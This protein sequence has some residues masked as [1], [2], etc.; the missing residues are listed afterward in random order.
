MNI[1]GLNLRSHNASATLIQD[2]KLITSVEEERLNREK[3]SWK[4]PHLSIEYSL[5]EAKID[6]KDIDAVGI[7]WKSSASVGKRL[8]HGFK[9]PT[10]LVT[11]LF[12]HIKNIYSISR[13]PADVSK[14][15]LRKDCKIVEVEHHLAHASSCFFV[16]PFEEAAILTLDGH[17]EWATTLLAEGQNKNIAKIQ[18]LYW[19]HSLGEF[20]RS[21]ASYLGFPEFGD[22]YKVMGLAPY[23]KPKYVEKVRKIVSY[24]NKDLFKINSDYLKLR[25]FGFYK[26]LPQD[27][28]KLFVETFGPMRLPS[29][30]LRECHND[31]AHS[32]QIVLNEVALKVTEKLYDIVKSPNLCMAGGVALN[33]VMNQH[34]LESSP[35][36]N[37]FVQPASN[38]AGVGFGAAYYLN[39]MVFGQERK[40]VQD[41]AYFGPSYSD[42]EIKKELDICQLNYKKLDNTASEVAKLLNEGKVIGWFQGRM[43]MGPRALGNRSI[44]AHPGLENIKDIVNARIKFREEFRPFA[45]SILEE[46]TSDYFQLDTDSSPYM[47]MTAQTLKDKADRVSG[48]VHVDNSARIQTVNKESNP[49]YWDLINEFYKLSGTPVILNTSFNVKGEPIVCSPVDAIRCFYST[50]LDNLVIGNYLLSKQIHLEQ[51]NFKQI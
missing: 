51:K 29:E 44:I 5:K 38:D 26:L 33:C 50:G 6:Y 13:N 18:E 45:P 40:F 9:R 12:N 39:H 28:T 37:L 2:G 23:G 31:I 35:F 30:E 20:Y 16:S 11:H 42:S 8:F 24:N 36:K 19:P 14:L 32:V 27:Y 4:F 7:G 17:G 21:F 15:P 41:H 10:T 25:S 46:H 22:E 49:L 47:L 43:E 34:I 1:L 3:F 48:I